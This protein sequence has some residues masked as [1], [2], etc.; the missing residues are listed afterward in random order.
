MIKLKNWMVITAISTS[1]FACAVDDRGENA[2]QEQAFYEQSDHM[3]GEVAQIAQGDVTFHFLEAEA[4]VLA[5]V[6]ESETPISEE[7]KALVS[8]SSVSALYEKLSGTAAPA[9]LVEAELRAAALEDEGPEESESDGNDAF[10]GRETSHNDGDI[11]TIEQNISA[12]EFDDRYCHSSDYLYCWPTTAGEPYVQRHGDA[13]TGAMSAVNCHTRFRFRY[14]RRGDWHTMVDRIASPG[15]HWWASD[16]NFLI[17]RSRR[18]E[19]IN[20]PGSCSV[21]FAVYGLN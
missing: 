17:K 12:S 5:I 8:G 4:G 16:A 13:M 10:A 20:N 3:A 21:R 11:R 6:L 9:K 19:V 2:G 1:A 14:Y 7:T 15:Q 18:F